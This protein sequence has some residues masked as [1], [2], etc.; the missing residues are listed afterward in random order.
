MKRIFFV[1]FVVSLVLLVAGC[2]ELIPTANYPHGDSWHRIDDSVSFLDWEYE[3][4]KATEVIKIFRLNPDDFKITMQYSQA[5]PKYI[6]EWKESNS[7]ADIIINGAYFHEDYTPS[8][9]LK[10]DYNR[11]GE[12]IFDQDLS[13]LLVIEN[14]K[15]SIRDLSKEPLETGE[16]IEFA[17]QSY[18]FLIK[19]S[20]RG[21][22]E[23][24][25]KTAYR[26]AIGIDKEGFMYIIIVDN[27][28][29]TL[30]EL[31]V[32]LI[33]TDI[34]FVHVLNLDGGTSTGILLKRGSYEEMH[35][36]LVKVPNVILFSSK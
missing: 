22:V 26:T 24:S 2:D 11:I 35:D 31:M 19:N 18:P 9:Y 30:Y 28:R 16:K 4:E 20:V 23:D 15:L 13:G 8:G 25:G 14:N 7:D 1:A 5:N 17:L 21:F 12:R 33:E 34:D 3:A 32:E 6:S 27:H 36:S 10:I 29:I